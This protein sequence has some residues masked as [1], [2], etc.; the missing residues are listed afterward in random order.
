MAEKLRGK[1]TPMHQSL[2]GSL[3]QLN[4]STKGGL[5]VYTLEVGDGRDIELSVV[6]EYICWR[7]VGDVRWIQLVPLSD[8]KGEKP[9]KGVDYFTQEDIDYLASILEGTL[10][11]DKSYVHIQPSASAEWVIAHGLNKMPS[12]TVE[13]SAGNHVIGEIEYIDSN[14]LNIKFSGAFSGRAYLN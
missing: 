14:N 5:N 12:V 6:D 10:G 8:L 3:N 9:E 13:D 4:Q 2:V 7:R 1:L 11:Q